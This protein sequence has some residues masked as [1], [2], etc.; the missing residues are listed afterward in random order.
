MRIGPLAK[1]VDAADSKSAGRKA[2]PV[3]IRGGPPRLMAGL[4]AASL[5]FA[6]HRPSAAKVP[7]GAPDCRA[8]HLVTLSDVMNCR[9]KPFSQGKLSEAEFRETLARI[10]EQLP[11]PAWESGDDGWP[12]I[13][14]RMLQSR[15]YAKGCRDCHRTYLQAYR[16][17]YRDRPIGPM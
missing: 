17:S 15:D 14:D 6:C 13:I 1:L 4:A 10:R 16:K 8:G 3:Q 5:L 2:I 9:M 7:A 12:E 11:D